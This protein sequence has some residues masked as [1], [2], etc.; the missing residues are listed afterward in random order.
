MVSDHQ[1]HRA[2]RFKLI[3]LPPGEGFA[4]NRVRGNQRGQILVL[5]CI[6][7][8]VP[9]GFLALAVDIGLLWN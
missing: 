4:M 3:Q 5:F 6:A 9:M 7:S 2:R 8:V 1:G